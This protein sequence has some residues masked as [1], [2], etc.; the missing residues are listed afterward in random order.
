[1]PSHGLPTMVLSISMVPTTARL[2]MSMQVLQGTWTTMQTHLC[3]GPEQQQELDY[4]VEMGRV[5]LSLQLAQ[6]SRYLCPCAEL[7]P[8]NKN[9]SA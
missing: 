6:H 2:H 9:D 1:M 3:Q 8:A 5:E 7:R 4:T